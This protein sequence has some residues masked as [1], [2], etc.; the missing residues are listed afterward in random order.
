MNHTVENRN[1]QQSTEGQK[2]VPVQV[3]SLP[4]KEHWVSALNSKQGIPFQMPWSAALNR[5]GLEMGQRT[6]HSQWIDVKSRE[7]QWLYSLSG[8]LLTHLLWS[9]IIYLNCY[10]FFITATD[11]NYYHKIIL[12]SAARPQNIYFSTFQKIIWKVFILPSPPAPT[13][14]I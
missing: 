9:L 4:I 5:L 8:C 13:S 2:P 11:T 1:N 14:K 3:Q 6:H 10:F 7:K 12:N